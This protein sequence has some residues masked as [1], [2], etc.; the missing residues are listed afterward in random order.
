MHLAEF[1]HIPR[2]A[3]FHG[4]KADKSTATSDAVA[5]CSTD[6]TSFAPTSV[7]DSAIKIRQLEANCGDHVQLSQAV[8]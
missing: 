2:V 1:C 4:R 8:C 3:H 5:L 6:V 7:L